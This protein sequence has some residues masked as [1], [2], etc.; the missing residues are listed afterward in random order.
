[1][2]FL[3]RVKHGEVSRDEEGRYYVDTKL[4]VVPMVMQSSLSGPWRSWMLEA[5]ISKETHRTYT[6]H[7]LRRAL[8][9]W[10]FGS[11]DFVDTIRGVA[12]DQPLRS[13]APQCALQSI[14]WPSSGANTSCIKR[15]QGCWKRRRASP[16]TKL[17][18]MVAAYWR[19]WRQQ[20]TWT[21]QLTL[22][23]G[24]FE[25]EN[26]LSLISLCEAGVRWP[27]I[28]PMISAESGDP[29]RS[30]TATWRA[31]S[32]LLRLD[33]TMVRMN[34]PLWLST[35]PMG[36]RLPIVA[37]TTTGARQGTPEGQKNS[38][39]KL[40]T[41]VMKWFKR[42]SCML[43]EE[44]DMFSLPIVQNKRSGTAMGKMP[45]HMGFLNTRAPLSLQDKPRP[46]SRGHKVWARA[47]SRM[48]RPAHAV[49][50][51]AV[52]PAVFATGLALDSGVQLSGPASVEP[53]GEGD[54][55]VTTSSD[56]DDAGDGL[57]AWCDLGKDSGFSEQTSAASPFLNHVKDDRWVVVPSLDDD[58]FT[59]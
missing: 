46:M 36:H 1:M 59:W 43:V 28:K 8:V 31:L 45:V 6:I 39:S 10:S 49:D 35:P 51:W 5:R 11:I 40:I 16:P 20:Q 27:S 41:L 25:K 56:T 55:S 9:D 3:A 7:V 30:D 29:Y 24:S 57:D 42:G 52:S 2:Q 54:E 50:L 44:C 48:Q 34:Q 18:R 17:T 15:A 53:E 23:N 26:G 21:R 38:R 37:R 47:A 19:D 58:I 32:E 22:C 12:V 14:A 33:I 4:F 13:M